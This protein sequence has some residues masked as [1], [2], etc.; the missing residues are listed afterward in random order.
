MNWCS[1][2]SR[3]SPWRRCSGTHCPGESREKAIRPEPEV[4]VTKNSR[5]AIFRLIAPGSFFSSMFSCVSFHSSTWC[6]NITACEPIS[7]CS[8]GTSSP[9]MW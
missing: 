5:P 6:S 4:R 7:I 9:R 8:S 3:P 2:T 1:R